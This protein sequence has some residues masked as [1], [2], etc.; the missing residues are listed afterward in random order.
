[1]RTVVISGGGTGIGVETARTFASLDYEVHILGRRAEILARAAA[2]INDQLGRTAAHA[3]PA[4][5][6]TASTIEPLLASLPAQIDVLVNNAGGAPAGPEE[7]LQQLEQRLRAALASN[8][9]SAALLTH[10]L[11]PRLRRPG[12]RV[13]NLSS[14]AALRGG[15]E[16]YGA[17]KAAVIALT[18]AQAT[19]LGSDGITVNAVAPGYVTDTQ[20][21][22]ETMTPERH[23]RLVAETLDGRP[24]RPADIAAAIAYLAAAEAGH[25]TAQ[26]LQVN[27]GALPGRG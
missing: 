18:Y 19:E 15:G 22:G 9:F 14:I 24:A 23:E 1:M 8:V 6:S 3:H 20:F 25:V 21:F 11:A 17:A 5:V 26:V 7:S 27:G 13:V 4:D 2:A 12:G 16:A 10:A